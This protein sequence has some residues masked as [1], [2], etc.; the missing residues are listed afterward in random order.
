M[1]ERPIGEVFDLVIASIDGNTPA[2]VYEVMKGR[3]CSECELNKTN[4]DMCISSNRGC[5]SAFLR[6]DNTQVVFKV[7]K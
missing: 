2:G 5:C 4:T 1:F 7:I 3:G 6:S